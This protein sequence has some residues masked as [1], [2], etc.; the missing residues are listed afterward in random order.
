MR[1]RSTL[2]A[3][4]TSTFAG[5]AVASVKSMRRFLLLAAI[6]LCVGAAPSPA[7]PPCSGAL[8][9]TCLTPLF[10][11]YKPKGSCHGNFQIVGGHVQ[12]V[13]CWQNKVRLEIDAAL[14][15]AGTITYRKANGKPCLRGTIVATNDATTITYR[16]GKKSWTVVKSADDALTVKCPNKKIEQYPAADVE[17][18]P[19]RCGGF[20]STECTQGPCP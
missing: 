10:A 3:A 5:M 14:T 13:D 2:G 11:C 18:Q 1:V 12:S 17:A 15:G 7:A 6:V 16:R 19:A 9:K 20:G 8:K 4:S